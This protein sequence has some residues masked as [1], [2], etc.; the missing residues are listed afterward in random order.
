MLQYRRTQAY[1]I[2]FYLFLKRITASSGVARLSAP[3][4]DNKSTAI[5]TPQ[6]CLQK[7]EMKIM[8]CAHLKI[9]GL[10]KHVEN[11]NQIPTNSNGS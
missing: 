5:S 10:I 7:L 6:I 4:A 8:F 2:R 3:G 11:H 9:Q 1:A